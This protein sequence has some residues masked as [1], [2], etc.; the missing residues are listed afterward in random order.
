[1]RMTRRA[2][3]ISFC[4]GILLLI[5]ACSAGGSSPVTPDNNPT[6]YASSITGAAYKG[7]G[8]V[9]GTNIYI[10]NLDTMKLDNSAVAGTNGEFTVGVN[11][12]QYLIFAFGR[13][14][15]RGVHV[16]ASPAFC[17]AAISFRYSAHNSE[18]AAA[19]AFLSS[20]R[21]SWA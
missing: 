4:L 11:A 14:G 19:M 9:P 15:W 13:D 2:S 5:G 8:P 17:S 20:S 10:Y 18:C 6:K 7:G 16:V 12:G 3:L 21:R 1:M